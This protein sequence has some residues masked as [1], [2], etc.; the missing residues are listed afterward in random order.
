MKDLY[1]ELPSNIDQSLLDKLIDEK[2]KNILPTIRKQIVSELHLNFES[3]EKQGEPRSPLLL[4][5]RYPESAED[6][7]SLRAEA[8]EKVKSFYHDELVKINKREKAKQTVEE[9]MRK[10]M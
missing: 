5:L 1:P 9:K 3:A 6:V 10:K 2:L 4:P 7:A 8:I